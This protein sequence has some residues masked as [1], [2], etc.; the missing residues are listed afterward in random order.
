MR[1]VCAM[2]SLPT[3]F[4]A[5]LRHRRYRIYNTAKTPQITPRPPLHTTLSTQCSPHPT[6][7]CGVVG[8]RMCGMMGWRAA[9]KDEG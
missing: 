9:I 5:S 8:K 1:H 2:R 7:Q 3:T 6:S 4:F